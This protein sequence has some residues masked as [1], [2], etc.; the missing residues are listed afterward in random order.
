MSPTL[1]TNAAIAAMTTSSPAYGWIARGAIAVDDGHIAWCGARDLLP[2][3]F[4]NWHSIDMGGRVITPALI[5]CHTHII[6][7]GNRAREF[8]MRLNGESYEDIASA[9]GGI[10][11][12]MKATRAASQDDLIAQALPRIDS[13]IAEGVSTIEIKSG[14]GLDLPSELKMLHAARHIETLRNVRIKTTYLG[15]HALPPDYKGRADTYIDTVCIPA[16]KTAH[17]AGLVDAV[18]GFCES[19]GFTRA[20]ITRVFN[21]AKDLGLPVK[22]H[23]EQLSNMHGAALTASYEGLSADHLEFIDQ[24]GIDAMAHAGTVA[25]MLPGAYYTLSETRKPPIDRFRAAQVPMAVA[26]DCNPGTSPIASILTVMNMACVQ[27]GMTPEEALAGTT[28]NAARALGLTDC[29]VLAPGLRA[30]LAVWDIDHP[31]DLSYRIGP[32]PLYQR[33]IGGQL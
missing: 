18:D 15:A 22:L 20:Q 19:I 1:L 14:Y 32:N 23:A 29:G 21:A 28:R 2:D 26:T 31:R 16:L 27:F 25:V 5:D 12:T 13:L 33:I 4:K 11:S 9:G 6:H 10:V 7:G 3:D 17:A 30:D 8:E 24:T